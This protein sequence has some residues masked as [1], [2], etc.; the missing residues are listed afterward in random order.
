M[1]DRNLIVHMMWRTYT[2]LAQILLILIRNLPCF[3]LGHQ[4]ADILLPRS[5][6]QKQSKA[7]ARKFLESEIRKHVSFVR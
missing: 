7:A 6:Y 4:V 5:N 3:I 2:C 1:L